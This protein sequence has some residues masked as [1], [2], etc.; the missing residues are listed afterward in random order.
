LLIK[1]ECS[2]EKVEKRK[3]KVC[4]D[5]MELGHVRRDCPEKKKGGSA[6]VALHKSDSDSDGDVLSVSNIVLSTEAW[7]LDSTSSFH[8]THKKE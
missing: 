4:Y 3:K 5:C 2:K 7:L 8:A 6:N 1:G